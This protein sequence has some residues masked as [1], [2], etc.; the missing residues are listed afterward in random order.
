MTVRN[1]SANTLAWILLISISAIW[2]SSFIL[3]KRGLLIFSAGELGAL[4]I[5]MAFL[6]LAPVAIKKIPR[7]STSKLPVLFVLGMNGS[8][9]PAFL[10]AIAQ[11][12]LDSAITGVINALTPIFVILIG[13]IFFHIKVKSINILGI[14]IGF[15]GIVLL[16]L[17]ASGFDISGVNYYA[18]F[19]VMATIMYGINVNLIKQ[20]TPDIKALDITAISLFLTSPFCLFYLFG[21]TEIV[22]KAS[23]ESQFVWAFTYVTILG[24][25]G[26]AGALVLFNRLVQISSPLFASSV[27][28]LI[29]LVAIMWGIMDGEIINFY[30]YVGMGIA[31][32]G[33]WLANKK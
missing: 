6:T 16:L 10:F 8:F 17:G 5:S 32:V 33:V 9:I 26:T 27:T 14:F 12:S 11:T 2:G 7:I 22:A 18:F 19:I 20:Y 24:V 21:F 31:L 23:W 15:S 30:Q 28:Y 3:I 4:R 29:P 1:S 13:F 25:I